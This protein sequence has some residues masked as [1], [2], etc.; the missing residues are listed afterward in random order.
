MKESVYEQK[1][2]FNCYCSL[3][4]PK[5]N[6]E[7]KAESKHFF[8]LM[9]TF[10]LGRIERPDF[11][12]IAKLEESP[13]KPL[14]WS[15]KLTIWGRKD[16]LSGILNLIRKPVDFHYLISLETIKYKRNQVFGFIENTFC[17]SRAFLLYIQ[18]DS[19]CVKSYDYVFQYTF[20]Y[21]GS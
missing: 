20:L 14:P 15:F 6:S 8:Y 1:K 7:R 18:R 19:A 11:L 17:Y 10:S 3:I 13:L 5:L 2:L 16:A 21:V 4:L 9:K 12:K